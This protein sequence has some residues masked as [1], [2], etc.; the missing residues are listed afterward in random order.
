MSMILAAFTRN[1]S[2]GPW[3]VEPSVG[4]STD[5][6]TNP[7]LKS[8]GPVSEQHVAVLYNLPLRYD[9]DSLELAFIPHG[10]FSN[11]SGYSSLSSNS[12]R[13]DADA[14]LISERGTLSLQT[15]AARD[16]SLYNNGLAA[17][18]YGVG[19]RQDMLTAAGDWTRLLTERSQFQF[20]AN[21]SRVH[22]DQ[23]ANSTNLV[24]YRY[25]SAGPTIAFAWS[26]RDTLKLQGNFGRYQALNRMTESKS[27]NLQLAF[28]RQLSEIWKFSAN[29]GYSRSKNSY[30]YFFGSFLLGMLHSNQ[31][32]TVY[33]VNLSRHGEQFN[34]DAGL[35]RALQ[36]TGFA[37]L[38]LQDN[39]ALHAAYVHSERWTLSLNAA[40]QRERDPTRSGNNVQFHYQ[41][42]QLTSGWHWTPQWVISLHV[43]HNS[44]QYGASTVSAAS[45]GVSLDVVRQ[46]LRTEL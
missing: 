4:V 8:I 28:D 13:V 3:S 34:L 12:A 22:Y 10:R 37:F 11:G 41:S 26:E 32:G 20:D 6:S 19:V 38:S 2:A 17:Y 39:V 43:S 24:D 23:P 25:L 46:F 36:P 40:L 30:N 44:R 5:Y 7:E 29:A 31:D 18:G 1:A 45:N 33:S 15:A 27:E 16:S 21:W 14:N 9:A 35:T 42:V